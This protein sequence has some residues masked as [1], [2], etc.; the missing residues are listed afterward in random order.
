MTYFQEPASTGTNR[1]NLF[2]RFRMTIVEGLKSAMQRRS[3]QREAMPETD[4]PRSG[5]P[6]SNEVVTKLSIRAGSTA[7]PW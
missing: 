7:G 6:V 3:T 4:F 1:I 2:T 5:M